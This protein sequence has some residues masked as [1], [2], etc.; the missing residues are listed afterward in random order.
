VER[1]TAPK[2]IAIYRPLRF[3]THPA[4]DPHNSPLDYH[5]FFH[6]FIPGTFSPTYP[7][8]VD[9]VDLIFRYLLA[10]LSTPAG[11]N[12]SGKQMVHQHE[13]VGQKAIFLFPVGSPKKQMGTLNT[14]ANTL[15]LLQEVNYWIQ[16]MDGVPFPL[17]PVGKFAMSCFSAG[18]RFLNAV[19]NGKRL[20]HFYDQIL[21]EVYLFDPVFAPDIR[22]SMTT[23]EIAAAK[24]VARR[25]TAAFNRGLLRWW[26]TGQ[27]NRS[28]RIYTQS[29]SYWDDLNGS[30][31]SPTLTIGP[32]NAKESEA[33]RT[34]ILFAPADN[35]WKSID[36]ALDYGFVHQ[37]IP[38]LFMEHAMSLNVF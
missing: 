13:A 11:L 5:L 14:Q 21:K 25:E 37:L 24:R 29:S 33:A 1:P 7:F 26:R 36:P 19:L 8:D 10:P 23:A 16:R 30:T 12:P 38:A 35:F 9:Y 32:S 15:R 34:T 3:G 22:Q 28:F 2:L 4:V 20:P 6:P 27:D 18:V 17:Q 31:I